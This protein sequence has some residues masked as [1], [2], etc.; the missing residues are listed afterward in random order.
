MELDD[1]NTK[2]YGEETITYSNNSPDAL[3]Y[4][5][6]QLDQNI[7]Q[8][9]APALEKNVTGFQPLTRASTFVKNYM[10][11]PF[12]GGFH[13]ESIKTTTWQATFLCDQSNRDGEWDSSRASI[14]PAGQY[15]FSSQRRIA[16]QTQSRHQQSPF[17]S[18]EYFPRRREQSMSLP[19]QFF[20]RMAAHN[21]V[22]G[23]G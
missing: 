14:P 17:G 10:D 16:N 18:Y 22:E 21:D 2:L 3:P 20:P 23:H 9:E 8:K 15:S 19:S 6:V 13:I 12:D 7:R 5:W 4:L 1:R 11:E